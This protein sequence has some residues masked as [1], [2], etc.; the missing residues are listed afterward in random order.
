[1][2]SQAVPVLIWGIEMPRSEYKT[3]M[4]CVER[5]LKIARDVNDLAATLAAL[6]AKIKLIRL[7]H[8]IRAT[9]AA[10]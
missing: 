1:M 8:A 7:H 5:A 6:T 2:P 3:Q 10:S 4:A 9:T